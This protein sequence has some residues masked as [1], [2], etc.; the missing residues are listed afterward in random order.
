M[1]PR[2]PKVST[3]ISLPSPTIT[4]T[5][6]SE[7]VLAQ[8][9]EQGEIVQSMFDAFRILTEENVRKEK[10]IE[11]LEQSLSEMK[12][13]VFLNMIENLNIL[14]DKIKEIIT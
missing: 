4:T 11:K 9:T 10:R 7:Q 1:L 5:S 6:S 14:R 13:F 3:S 12:E 8:L 2:E